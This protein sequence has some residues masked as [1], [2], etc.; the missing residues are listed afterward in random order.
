MPNYYRFNLPFQYY[1]PYKNNLYYNFP[2]QTTNSF[3]KFNQNDNYSATQNSSKTEN[4]KCKHSQNL[5]PNS[6]FVLDLFGLH[7]YFDDVLILGLL[8]FLYKEDVKDE[9]LFLA[10]VMLL[11]S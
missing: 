8:F 6:D 4:E 2:H 3:L 7:L 11:I 10:L 1:R 5:P 9:G